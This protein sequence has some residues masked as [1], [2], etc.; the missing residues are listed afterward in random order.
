[1]FVPRENPRAL[2]IRQ[3]DQSPITSTTSRGTPDARDIATPVQGNDQSRKLCISVI[4]GYLFEQWCNLL[5]T[6]VISSKTLGLALNSWVLE[7]H[8]CKNAQNW[9]LFH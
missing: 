1:M 3:P 4:G 5:N 6:L 2:F 7:L 9:L 8:H